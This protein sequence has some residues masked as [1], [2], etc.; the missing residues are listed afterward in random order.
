MNNSAVRGLLKATVILGFV[1]IVI[2]FLSY[3]K[4]LTY[5]DSF[6]DVDITYGKTEQKENVDGKDKE[7]TV[8]T[9]DYKKIYEKIN[10]E[11]LEYNLGE[12]FFDVYYGSNIITDEYYIFVGLIHLL[13][14][15]TVLNCNLVKEIGANDV[16]LKIKELFGNVKYIKKSFATANDIFKVEYNYSTDKYVVTTSKCSGFDFDN[17]GIKN[18]YVNGEIKGDY[19]YIYEKSLYLNYTYDGNGNIIFNYHANINKDSDI[20][21]NSL[22]KINLDNIATYKYIFKNNNGVYTLESISK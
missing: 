15:E 9:V 3:N 12:D 5:K 17:G 7:T 22:D 19:L 8:N 13:N 4:W 14:N 21:A 20:I 1:F 6:D 16:D 18:I 10:Y 11:F 2:Y